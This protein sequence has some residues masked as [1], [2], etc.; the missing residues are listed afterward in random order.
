MAIELNVDGEL[1]R[2]EVERVINAGYSG[3]D[4]ESVQEHINELAEEGLEPPERV[5]ISFELA[6]YTTLVDPGTVTVVG[7]NT[8]G[9]AEY[10]LLVAGGETYIVAASDQTDRALESQGIQLSK[11]IAPNVLSRRAWRLADV[12]DRWDDIEIR[13]WNTRDGE[14]LVYQDATLGEILPPEDILE[15]IRE[16][17]GGPLDGTLVLSGMVPTVSGELKPGE[18]FEVELRDPADGRSIG[19]TYDVRTVEE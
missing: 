18:R 11:Q 10:G 2:A 19:M 17:Y 12:R 14:R 16:R 4:Q 3:R 13:A 7:G 8:S 9:E 6:P 15:L 5:P 1:V